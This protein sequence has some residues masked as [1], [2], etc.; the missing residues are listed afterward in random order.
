MTKQ[1]TVYMKV[2]NDRYELPIAIEDTAKA[3]ARKLGVGVSCIHSPIS[4]EK[5]GK[6]KHSS[7]KRVEIEE[8]D[9]TM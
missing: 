7:Y 6:V 3:L 1:K 9:D 4:L 5:S 2:T 8:E